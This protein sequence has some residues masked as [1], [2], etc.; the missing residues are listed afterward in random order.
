MKPTE[1][2]EYPRILRNGDKGDD[3]A[4][5]QLALKNLGYEVA[6]T[7][8]YDAATLAAVQRFQTMNALKS[9]G[10]FGSQSAQM[11]LSGSARRADD[12]P[13]TFKTLR[14]DNRDTQDNAIAAM[15]EK[16]KE[17]GYRVSVNGTYDV[18]THEA[19]VAFQ[20]RNNLVVSGIA[21]PVMQAKL[22]SPG[23]KDAS[24]PVDDPAP[25]AGKGQGPAATSVRLLHWFNEIKPSVSGRQ[26]V[27][28][29]DPRSGISFRIRFYALGNHADSEPASLTDTLLMNRAFGL[30]SWVI[31]TVYVQLPSGVWTL[32][33]MHNRP[34][35]SGS[36]NDN[37]FGGHLCV[38][39][40]RDMEEV[41]RSDPNHGVANQRAIRSAWKS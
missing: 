18:L 23:A 40:L 13:L 26:T 10:V 17:L 30:P 25:D 15:Q 5:M 41:Q 34:H 22:F 4:K 9:D 2:P 21:D 32:A 16:L 12:A 6:V 8:T 3:V 24:V 28:V 31:R 36:I 1:A 14:I 11:L 20:R 29:H 39:F 35:L 7:G 27:T 38:H 19:V 37:G 33:S